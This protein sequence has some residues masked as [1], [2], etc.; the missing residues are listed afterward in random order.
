VSVYPFLGKDFFD[1]L[2]GCGAV[3]PKTG[4]QPCHLETE[5][6]WMPLYL[7]S[8]SRGE[9]VFDYSWAEAYHRHGLAYYP[10]LVTSIPFTPVTGPRWR[11]DLSAASLWSGVKD[12]M[13]EHQAS[14]WH[15]LFPDAA[16]REQLQELP[17]VSRQACHF[18]WLNRDYRDFEDFLGQF[19]SRKRKNLR[20]ERRRVQ[21]QGLTITRHHGD[22]ISASDWAFFYQCY[23][24]TYLKRGQLP[25]LNEAFFS[26]VGERLSEQ[27]MLVLARDGERPVAAALYFFDAE[28]LYGRYWGCLEERDALHFELCYYQGIE[29]AIEQQL[30]AFDPGVQ[31]EHKILRGFEPVI[32]WSMHHLREPA[33]HRA[34][35]DFCREEAVHVQRYREEAMTLLPFR[36]GGGD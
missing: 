2:Q 32:T 10:K 6:G 12:R 35:A 36:K 18:R 34:I 9:Y 21:E 8:H 33:F 15:L 1:A 20:K 3:A 17:L 11:G 28:C 25:Y 16:A 31:G 7:R 27:L 22:R 26:A 30:A 14:G 24:S 19:Q 4:W 13:A 5:Q 23:A 29:F